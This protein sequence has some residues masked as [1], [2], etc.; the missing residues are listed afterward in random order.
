MGKNLNVDTR[1]ARK[2]LG[3]V[4]RVSQDD[5]MAEIKRWVHTHYRAP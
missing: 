2:E 4:S 1:R 5:A 3:W